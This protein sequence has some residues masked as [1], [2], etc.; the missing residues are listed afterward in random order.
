MSFAHAGVAPEQEP[1]NNEKFRASDLAFLAGL[2]FSC[3]LVAWL[4]TRGHKGD[5]IAYYDLS[6]AIQQH[7]WQACFNASWSPLY[8]ALL[9]AG[10]A[11]FGFNPRYAAAAGR[12][13]N[14]VIVL[15]LLAS[16][17]FLATTIRQYIVTRTS[18]LGLLLSRPSLMIWMTTAA[19]FLWAN[20]MN[21]QKPDALLTC[22]FLFTTGLLVRGLT[23][24]KWSPFIYAGLTAGCAYWTKSFAFPFISLLVFFLMIAYR[25]SWRTLL[26]LATTA[27]VFLCVA[28]PY[29]SHISA[30]KHRFTIGDAG[31]LNSAW[32]VNGAERQNPVADRRI[33]D[34]GAALGTYTHPA[35][36]LSS[37]PKVSYFPPGKVFGA[38]PAWADFSYW[39]DG[40]RSQFIP[41]QTIHNFIA[42]SKLLLAVIP[43]RIQ[44]L[45]LF[46]ALWIFGLR[47]APRQTV[48]PALLAI[49]LSALVSVALYLSVHFEGRYIV[50]TALI[51]GAIFA[52]GSHSGRRLLEQTT[53]HRVL[54][55]LGFL[56]LVGEVESSI[57][58]I[59]TLEA[60]DRPARAQFDTSEL[61]VGQ[62]L[63]TLYGPHPQ[64][65][66]LGLEA[67][68]DDSLWAWYGGA[69]VSATVGLAHLQDSATPTDICKALMSAGPAPLGA[70]QQRQMHAVIG[71]FPAGYACSPQWQ[72]IA[73]APGYYLLP[74]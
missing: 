55:V 27:L 22:L 15:G 39:S 25:K 10:R 43:M 54:L 67:C 63:V 73:D 68:Y 20:D 53:L 8:P 47:L 60:G 14:F 9:T 61:N 49:V 4:E 40:L 37:T 44:L 65:A 48:G 2:I 21:G 33:D 7:R 71:Y 45:A 16:A 69:T 24:G 3:F 1:E 42:N 5:T 11:L 35:D 13:V 31:R 12:L 36:L 51:C 62:H 38:M 6:N 58:G 66:C 29:I 26:Q 32:Y 52:A 50:F 46:A 19:F 17:Y 59:K 72:P 70:L 34:F 64:V 18:G 74:L 23:F 41:R 28:L 56:L 57:R 30:Q